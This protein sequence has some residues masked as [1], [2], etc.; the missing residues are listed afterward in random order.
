[1]ATVI[2][3][4]HKRLNCEHNMDEKPNPAHFTLHVHDGLELLYFISDAADYQVEGTVYRPKA[5]D[6]LIMRMAEVHSLLMPPNAPP[7]E[8]VSVHFSPDLLKETLNGRLLAPFLERPLGRMNH[9]PSETLPREFVRMCF[10]RMLTE[11]NMCNEMRV[12]TYLLPVLQ[13]L[14]HIWQRQTLLPEPDAIIPPAAKIIAYINQHLFELKGLHEL[15]EQFYLSRS[16]INRI[17]HSFTG[18]SVWNYVQI[19]RLFSARE[20]LQQGVLPNHAAAACGYQEYSTFY[21]AYKK[22]FGRSPLEDLRGNGLEGE[23]AP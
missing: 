20:L 7:Y 8:R 15:E 23:N 2:G 14:Y 10:D 11:E 3:C 9:Y 21:R 19:K 16:Q 5:G 13:E 12:L 6:I 4:S 22:H 1:M 17:F 18:T